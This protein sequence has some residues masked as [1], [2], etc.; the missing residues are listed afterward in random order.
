MSVA[1]LLLYLASRRALRRLVAEG[2]CFDLIDAHYVYPDGVAAIWL[3]RDFGK[4]V[5]ITARGS[6]MT[7]L[8]NHRVPRWMIRRRDR[9][10][11]RIDRRQF[12]VA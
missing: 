10:R 12:G 7:E 2:V 5:V 11:R 1:P 4:P 9:P 6:D 3:G 8:P